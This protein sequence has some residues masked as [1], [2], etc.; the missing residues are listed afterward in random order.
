[1][2]VKLL[3][4]SGMILINCLAVLGH[5]DG[6]YCY[7]DDETPYGYFGTKT[8]YDN[9]RATEITSPAEG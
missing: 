2:E 9:V 8:P 4:S 7:S 3:V 5:D 1:M 6:D